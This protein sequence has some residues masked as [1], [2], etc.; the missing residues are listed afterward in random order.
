MLSRTNLILRLSN[1]NSK[2]IRWYTIIIF[3]VTSMKI[4]NIMKKFVKVSEKI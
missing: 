3:I 1:L 4:Y 2:I